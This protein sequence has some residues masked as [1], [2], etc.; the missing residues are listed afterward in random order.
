MRETVTRRDFLK[1]GLLG[2]TGVVLVPRQLAG[3]GPG[4]SPRGKHLRN[5]SQPLE[6]HRDRLA[7]GN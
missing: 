4:G 7:T 2:G 1:T 3:G 6:L 5:V